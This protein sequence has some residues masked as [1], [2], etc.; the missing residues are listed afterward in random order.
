MKPKNLMLLGFINSAAKYL[1]RQLDSRTEE[2]IQDL[3]DSDFIEL[4]DE[5]RE[6]LNSSLVSMQS[7]VNTLLHAGEEAFDDFMDSQKQKT[8]LAD[9]LDSIFDQDNRKKDKDKDLK[10]LLSFYNLNDIDV[11]DEEYEEIR[12]K[13][14]ERIPE[15]EKAKNEAVEFLPEDME[16][17][18]ENVFVMSDEDNELLQQ[19]ANNV[20]KTVEEKQDQQTEKS[21]GALDDIFTEVMSQDSGPEEVKEELPE[22]V[23]QNDI[24]NLVK[25]IQGSKEAYFPGYDQIEETGEKKAEEPAKEDSYVSSLIDDLREKMLQEDELKKTE[26]EEYNQ[27]YER[28][29]RIYPYLS[30]SFIKSVYDLRDTIDDEYPLN[31]NLVVLHRCSFKD[32]E[33]LRQFVEIALS[34]NYTINADEGKL[35]VDVM[36]EYLNTSGKIATSIYEVANQSALLNG[37]YEGYN[38]MLSKKE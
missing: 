35:I 33:S 17:E 12:D 30:S 26:E 24:V 3:D 29:H 19:I 13:E 5:M 27:A 14:E 32:V 23:D 18:E 16:D 15:K 34:H 31:E 25:D 28:I 21:D 8:T 1:D 2:K 36:K 4:S 38:V 6:E 20:N 9:E 10:Q 11:S 22:Q 37:S 7:A